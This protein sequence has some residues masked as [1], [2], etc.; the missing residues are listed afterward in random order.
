MLV[1]SAIVIYNAIKPY[2]VTAALWVTAIAIVIINYVV[3]FDHAKSALQPVSNHTESTLQPANIEYAKTKSTSNTI[4]A[5]KKSDKKTA[6]KILFAGNELK[7]YDAKTSQQV[8][9]TFADFSY[10]LRTLIKNKA[11]VPAIQPNRVPTD[12]G[13]IGDVKKHKN[14]FISMMLPLAL[15]INQDIAIKRAELLDIMQVYKTTG[16]ITPQQQSFI[17]HTTL[18]FGGKEDWELQ[19]VLDTLWVRV[20]KLPV[21]LILAQG[22]IESGWGTSRFSIEGNAL[23]G[24]WTWSKGKGM[25]PADR[26]KGKTHTIKVFSSPYQSMKAYVNNIN[27]NPAYARLRKLRMSLHADNIDITGA[28]LATTLDKYSQEREAYVQKLLGIISR[29]NLEQ[30]NH[31]QIETPNIK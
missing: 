10:D 31:L 9:Q 30:Y 20:D 25:V 18:E 24:Q 7:T 5:P 22:A 1:R 16:E 23:F 11:K 27:R 26:A 6:P 13:K 28:A 12:L 15:K 14:L 17:E 19:K 4:S 21:S 2:R 8:E 29:D 3:F